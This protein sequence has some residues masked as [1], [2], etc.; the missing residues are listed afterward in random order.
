M[1]VNTAKV[2]GRRKLDFASYEELLADAE[3]VT[4][5]PV[6]TLG[7]W[8]PGQIFR[9]L[10]VTYNNSIDGFPATFPWYFRLMCKVF[11]KKILKMAMPAGF[12]LKPQAAA[13]MEPG[14]TSTAEGLAELRAAI[15]RIQRDPTR[16]KHP[17]FGNM[18]ENE[19]TQMNL[20]HAS[21]HM[22]F[23]VPA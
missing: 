16:V 10:A 14:P 6:K 21:L 20:K 8:S 11:K 23:I 3:Q 9:H 19:W 1:P 4:S 7:N 18:T 17:A 12:K 5:G 15:D 13:T 2:E 22:S